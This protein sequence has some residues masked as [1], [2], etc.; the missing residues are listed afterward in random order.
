MRNHGW[1]VEDGIRMWNGKDCVYW[2][3]RRLDERS[4]ASLELAINKRGEFYHWRPGTT[5]IPSS[6]SLLVLRNT[7][8]P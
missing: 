1:D 7:L 5:T 8:S 3:M 2:R 4:S 6:T